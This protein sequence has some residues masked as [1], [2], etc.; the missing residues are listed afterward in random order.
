MNDPLVVLLKRVRER[1]GLSQAY[2]EEKMNLPHGTYRHIE[3]GRR[4]L[5]DIRGGLAQWI[6]DFENA[7]GASKAE[8]VEILNELARV[9]LDQFRHLLRDLDK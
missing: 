4:Q 8:R 7:V 3:H 9:I 2:V 6:E 1:H 5:P